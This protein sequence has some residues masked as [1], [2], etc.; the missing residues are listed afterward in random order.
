MSVMGQVDMVDVNLFPLL[1]AVACPTRGVFD[2]MLARTDTD[3][4][5]VDK[6][7]L[8]SAVHTTLFISD[9]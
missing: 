9:S 7:S 8:S 6:N 3:L 1:E 4:K 2:I 5:A